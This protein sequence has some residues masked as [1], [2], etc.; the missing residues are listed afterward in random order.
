VK[1]NVIAKVNASKNH[2]KK[3]DKLNYIVW[4]TKKAVDNEANKSVVE[5]MARELGIPKFKITLVN[6]RK[7]KKKV[8][9]IYYD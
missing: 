1:I 9:E 3:I 2:V 7:N 6:G 5:L 8:L 4:T